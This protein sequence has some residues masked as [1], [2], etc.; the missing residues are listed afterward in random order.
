MYNRNFIVNLNALIIKI[1]NFPSYII[2]KAAI[3]IS[4]MAACF[5]YLSMKKC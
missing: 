1:Y 2:L 5:K 4:E 3:L